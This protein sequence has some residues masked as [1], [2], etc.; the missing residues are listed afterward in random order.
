MFP[1][2]AGPS[3]FRRYIAVFFLRTLIG[4]QRAAVCSGERAILNGLHR[5]C[6]ACVSTVVLSPDPIPFP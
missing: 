3:P 4:T 2:R 5:H 6:K 1:L